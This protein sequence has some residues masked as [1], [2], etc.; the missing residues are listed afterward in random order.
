MYKLMIPEFVRWILDKFNECNEK[1]PRMRPVYNQPLKQHPES[2]QKVIQII[3]LNV[4]STHHANS[5]ILSVE[6]FII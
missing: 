4:T 3:N 1:T 6:G 2:E 5:T